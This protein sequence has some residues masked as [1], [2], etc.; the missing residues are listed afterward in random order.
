M[1]VA[2]GGGSLEDL[3]TFNEEAVARAIT[4][5]RVPVVSAVGHE[6]DVTIADFV[7]DLRAPTPSAAVE[8]VV[9]ARQEVLDQIGGLRH[10]LTQS[11]RYRLA[12]LSRTLEQQ[13]V[14]RASSLLHRSI[15][16][17][18]QR[19]DELQYHLRDRIRAV[20]LE[21]RRGVQ[22]LEARVRYY[23]PRPRLGR[24]R[25][26]HEAA[27]SAAVQSIRLQLA[28]RRSR[29]ESLEAKL[30]QLSPLAILNR[31][32]AIVTNPAGKILTDAT[33]SEERRVGKECRL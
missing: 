4:A 5:C 23:D 30:S 24:N 1:I 17:Y 20:L 21:R 11:I 27:V 33:R 7:A 6:M 32:Y 15:G 25:R 28:R 2:R 29:L 26:R 16:R 10:K 22:G 8:L 9:R 3:W 18:Q 13:G 19:V 31:G 14:A 12:M